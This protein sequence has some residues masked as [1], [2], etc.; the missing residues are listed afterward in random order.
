MRNSRLPTVIKS[1]CVV[2]VLISQFV[3]SPV[4]AFAEGDQPAATPETTTTEAPPVST[5]APVAP[6]SDPAPAPA[7]TPATA[8]PGPKK[9]NGADSNTYHYNEATGL[10]ENDHYTWNPVTK[11]T[12]PK[13]AVDYSYNPT[14]GMWDTTQW[15]YDAASGK[16]EPNVVSTKENPTNDV[17]S[18]QTNASA[19]LNAAKD[20]NGDTPQTSSTTNHESGSSSSNGNKDKDDKGFF[21]LFNNSSISNNIISAAASGGAEILR[22]TIAGNAVTGMATVV[23]NVVNLLQ[24]SWGNIAMNNLKTFVS[25]VFGNVFGDLLI[26]PG[27]I[28]QSSTASSPPATSVDVNYQNNGQITNNLDLSAASGNAVVAENTKA[29]DAQSGNANV[30]ANLVNMINS[31]IGAGDSFLG[32][33][34]I[35]GNLDGDILLPPG[36]INSLLQSNN[37]QVA[38]LNTPQIENTEVLANL[39]NNQSISNNVNL[40]AAS[41][42]ADVSNNTSAGNATTG[43]AATNLTLLNLT[44]RQVVGNNAF[45]VFVNVLGQ[46]VGLIVDAPSGATAAA[47]GG[48]ITQNSSSLPAASTTIN[49]TSNSGITNNINGRAQSGDASVNTNTQAGNATTGDATASA[50]LVNIID[51]QFSLSNWLGILFINVFGTWHG[52]FGLDTAAGNPTNL[53]AGATTGTPAPQ[54]FQFV[55]GSG[56]N[57]TRIVRLPSVGW[58]GGTSNNEQNQATLAAT[59]T[60]G[61]SI[62]PADTVP[63]EPG[64]TTIKKGWPLY[65][66]LGSMLGVAALGTERVVNKR[67]KSVR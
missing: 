20:S 61:N 6:V 63:S 31:T 43:N 33:V 40:A 59:T 55:A 46:W 4:V 18:A 16:Y 51:S 25:D 32:V 58:S 7:P 36:Y 2:A 24:S 39:T 1:I 34:N 56:G 28:G 62:P 19:Q 38:T 47:L 29:G 5:P 65:S 22:N 23:S 42:Q 12:Q 8:T 9:P 52:S 57:K 10:W 60:N 17:A 21:D 13:D 48:G 35:Y 54:V 44:G 26:N 49:A 41:G 67:K 50:N 37:P 15:R 14:T 45:L 64:T 3:F 30:I 27:E 66:I 53:P 11:Q